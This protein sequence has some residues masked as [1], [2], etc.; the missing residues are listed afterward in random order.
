MNFKFQ[1]I[2]TNSFTLYIGRT[3][4]NGFNR[5]RIRNKLSSVQRSFLLLI[6]FFIR[7]GFKLIQFVLHSCI[8]DLVIQRGTLKTMAGGQLQMTR[9]EGQIQGRHLIS[10]GE[11][12]VKLTLKE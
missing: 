5:K 12:I 2:K 6:L 3:P 9:I 4:V 8:Y 11:N 1:S 7:F 10:E